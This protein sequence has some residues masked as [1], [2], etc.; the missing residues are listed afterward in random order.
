MDFFAVGVIVY[1]IMM[2]RRPYLGKNRQEIKELILAKQVFIRKDEI[3]E[4]WSVESADF[5]NKLLQRKPLKRLGWG[6]I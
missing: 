1:E 5:A 2:G 3:P 6:G 4:G